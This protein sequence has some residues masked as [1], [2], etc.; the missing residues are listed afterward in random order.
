MVSAITDKGKIYWK[1]HEGGI[2]AEKFKG[3]AGR[4]IH[5]KK[6]KVFLIMDNAKIH[7]SRI[8]TE[9]AGENKKSPPQSGGVFKI[10]V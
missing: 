8:L 3:F 2:N 1:L 5:G 7:H 4:L 10:F 6:R 9:W